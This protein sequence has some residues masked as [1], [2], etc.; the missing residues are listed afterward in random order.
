M[1]INSPLDT[2]LQA[3]RNSAERLQS[4]VA[5]LQPDQLKGRAYPTEWTVADVLSHLGSGAV[6]THRRIDDDLAGR[7][8]P[9]EFP[10]SVWD[11]WNAKSP[12]AKVHDGLAA[13]LA[14]IKRIE[15]MTEGER[16][17]FRMSFGPVEVDLAGFTGLRLNEHALHTWDIEV[18]GDPAATLAPD[19]AEIIVDNLELIGR[20]TAKP[21]GSDRTITVR[22]SAPSR[23]FVIVLTPDSATFGTGDADRVPDIEMS[24]EA[25]SRLVYGRL[26][27]QHTPAF[28]GDAGAL[29][30][31]RRV[32]PGP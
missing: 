8:M 23:W 6:I 5:A 27:A 16:S 15:A 32:F 20:F 1:T 11:E 18:V 9:E 17:R 25:F 29:D 28:D 31:L 24:A 3:L 13:G 26:D 4:L 22:T 19:A 7:P 30:E 14:L 2:V 21:T 12:T 10:K